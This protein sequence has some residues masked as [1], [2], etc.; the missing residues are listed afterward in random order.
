MTQQAHVQ[1]LAEKHA[2]LE[3]I[4]AEELTRPSPDSLRIAEL[5]RQKLKIKEEM[6]GMVQ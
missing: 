5:K 1:A 2:T 3:R 4:I 6:S